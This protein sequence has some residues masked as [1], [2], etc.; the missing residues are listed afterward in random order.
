MGLPT[1]RLPVMKILPVCL[2]L[3]LSPL[4]FAEWELPSPDKVQHPGAEASPVSSPLSYP[5]ETGFQDRAKVIIEGVATGSLDKWRRG[6]FTGGDPGK[7]LPGHAMAKLLLNPEDPEP[8]KYFNDDRSYKEHYHFAAVNWARF[9]PIFGEQVLTAET[10]QRLADAAFKYGAYGNPNG[11][12]N[13]KVMW[14]TSTNVLPHY[15]VGGRGLAHRSKE[16]TLTQAGP[17]Y[18]CLAKWPA[19]EEAAYSFFGFP[20]DLTPK[21]IDG[22]QVFESGD[23]V[24]AICMG[25]KPPMS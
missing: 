15:L 24:I 25:T 4:G 12:D 7:Y 3:F 16:A 1:R 9:L 18:L 5:D 8:A 2:L 20:E 13:H 19:D 14:W 23:T 21:E 22:W 17:L 6:Y 11:T 10:Q